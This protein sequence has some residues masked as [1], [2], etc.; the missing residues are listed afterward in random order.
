MRSSNTINVI[1]DRREA[2]LF[3]YYEIQFSHV[4]YSNA[5]RRCTRLRMSRATRRA[6]DYL[7]D[8]FRRGV[9]GDVSP[10]RTGRCLIARVGKVSGC[11]SER[12]ETRANVLDINL[13]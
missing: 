9:S 12:D 13:D 3:F 7:Q 4:H 1:S 11:S 10:W 6:A 2:L 8:Y 5:Q